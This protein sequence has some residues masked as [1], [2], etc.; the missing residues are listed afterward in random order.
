MRR[1]GSARRCWSSTSARSVVGS[2]QAEK[3]AWALAAAV[4]AY[5]QKEVVGDAARQ[6]EALLQAHSVDIATVESTA[7][8]F[9]GPYRAAVDLVATADDAAMAEAYVVGMVVPQEQHV[10]EVGASDDIEGLFGDSD[11]GDVVAPAT[12]D[13]QVA[14][15]ASFEMAHREESTRQF[16]A[17]ERE[18]LAAML[19]VCTNAA[20]EAARA[21]EAALELAAR[22]EA[23]RAEEVAREAARAEEASAEAAAQEERWHGTAAAGTTTWPRRDAPA[24]STSSLP[25][26]ATAGTWLAAR[27]NAPARPAARAPTPSIRAGATTCCRRHQDEDGGAKAASRGRVV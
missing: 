20:R 23:A 3:E 9:L 1:R 16:M 18:A 10:E 11:D 5:Q 13:E 6:A 15:I 25:S 8:P 12:T 2:R 7:G 22:E 21:A 27:L 17:A 4:A 14:L 26:V 19:M 24:R